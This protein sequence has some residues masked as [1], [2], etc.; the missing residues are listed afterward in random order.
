MVFV[1]RIPANLLHSE[2]SELACRKP[3]VQADAKFA[4]CWKLPHV[5][6]ISSSGSPSLWPTADL[7]RP[8]RMKGAIPQLCIQALA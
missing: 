1:H 2:E 6:H 7:P 8:G 3:A 5:H 4:A